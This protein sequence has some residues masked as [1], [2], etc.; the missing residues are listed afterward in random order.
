MQ[1]T[2]A[3][4]DAQGG[5]FEIGTA[6]LDSPRADEVLVRIRAVGVCHTDI[7]A[8]AGAFNFGVPAVLGHEG[9]GVVEAV[10]DAVEGFAPGDRV[11]ISFRSCG[12]CPKCA[13]HHPA[14]CHTMPLLNY[15]G[16][17]PDGTR[18]LSR[19]GAPLAS[20]FFGQ[21]S[22]ASHALTYARNLVKLPDDMP[23]EVAAPMGCGIQTGAGSVM[24]ALGCEPGSTLLVTGGGAVGLSAVM[25]AKIRGCAAILVAEPMA[26]RRDLALELGAT[27]VFDPAAGDLAA[28]V[29]GV[30]PIGV[31]YA[32]DT[33]GRQEVLD[34]IMNALGPQGTL[35]LVGIGAPGTRLPGD[36][37]QAMTFGHTVKGIIE[38]DSEPSSFLPQ[39]FEHYRRGALPIDRLVATYPFAAI[40]AAID[41]QHHGKVVK[42]V[43]TLPE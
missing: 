7:V 24:N 39:L 41:D 17:R 8:Q 30:L 3:I 34:A 21:S 38:G 13:A 14:Y 22:F 27:H 11:A 32:F 20:N 25:A 28:W 16:M 23:F 5:A 33:T 1:V 18:A 26:A 35:G 36:L 40:N 2:A 6:E 37:T 12:A 42:V 43:L 15:A 10:G 29:R 9:A 4:T 31:D 19:D